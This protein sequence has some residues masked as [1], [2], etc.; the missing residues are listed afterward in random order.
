MPAPYTTRVQKIFRKTITFTG[1]ANLGAVGTVA[2]ATVTGAVWIT[3][4]ACRC[5]TLLAGASATVEVGDATNTAALIAQTTGTDI[6]TGE[7]WNS[8]TPITIGPPV[9]NKLLAANAI[10]TVATADVDS[11]VL[12]FT[13]FWHPVSSDGL[14]A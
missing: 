12:E 13:F 3:A 8:A 11:G 5:T 10:I 14:I 2:L 4:L 6:D 1:A 9:L 7:F